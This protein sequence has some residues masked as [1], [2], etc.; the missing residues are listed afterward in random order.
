MQGSMYRSVVKH[1]Q[2]NAD[3]N[4][5]FEV[6]MD[7]INEGNLYMLRR[8]CMYISIIY[9]LMIVIALIFVPDFKISWVHILMLPLMVIQ[10]RINVY[11]LNHGPVSS[12]VTVIVCCTFYFW[13]AMVFI[14]IDT[15]VYFDKQAYFVPMLILVFPALYIDRMY[16]YGWEELVAA[17]TFSAFSYTFKDFTLFRRD[18]YMILGAYSV[19]MV[20]GH[21]IL[22]M[23][24]REAL[25]M[26]ELKGESSL[27]K[28]THV[29][30]KGALL[31]KIDL[32]FLQKPEDDYCAMMILDLDDFK[33]VNDN[34]GHNTGDILLEHVGRLL[35][36]SFRAYDITGR[37]GGDEFVVLMPQMSD[38]TIL[39]SRCR[40]LQ[41]L[42]S[43]INLGNSEPFTMSIGAIISNSMRDSNEVFMM[44]DDALYKSKIG[45][46]NN[47]TI[48][49]VDYRH[50]EK[51]ILISIN[52]GR[53]EAIKKLKEYKGENFEILSAASDNDAL[54]TISQYHKQLKLVLLEVN[55]DNEFGVLTMRYMKQR[56]SF[57]NIPILA[58][59][60]SPEGEELARGLG[61]DK[62]LMYTA[63]DDEFGKTIDSLIRM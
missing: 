17:V 19:S 37:Y 7:S 1:K 23:R 40:A 53:M 50:Y 6:C 26:K 61:A 56:E 11:L 39:Q 22:E 43:N 55:E 31:S 10:Y 30:N 54:C 47:C 21:L 13:L 12:Q 29:F 35:L 15:V 5:Y 28:L 14:L 3:I 45:G 18:V 33:S 58:V 24:S 8:A 49:S 27:D 46:K 42:L 2:K 57:N 41:K 36:D 20:L 9:L 32:Y 34:L 52:D 63:S 4:E 44:A 25:A 48:W 59:V 16:K 51:P 38:I 60:K 62:V